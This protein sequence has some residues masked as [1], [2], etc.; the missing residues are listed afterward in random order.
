M[1]GILEISRHKGLLRRELLRRIGYTNGL[2]DI[3]RFARVVEYLYPLIPSSVSRLQSVIVDEERTISGAKY[4]QGVID[5]AGAL[6]LLER[7][8]LTVSLSA[9]G[10]A[11]HALQQPPNTERHWQAFLLYLVVDADGEAT[12]NL[13]D[14]LTSQD[15]PLLE[16]GRLLMDRMIRLMDLKTEWANREVRAGFVKGVVVGEI[17]DARKRLISALD[18][19]KKRLTSSRTLI[20]ERRLSAE[21]RTE[22]FIEHTIVPRRGWLVDLG[23]MLSSGKGFELTPLGRQLVDTFKSTSWY[24]GGIIAMPLSKTVQEVLSVPGEDFEQLLWRAIA[25]A[26]SV[27][28]SVASFS[29]QD[30]LALIKKLYPHLKLPGLNEAEVSALF[31]A[32]SCLEAVDGRVLDRTAF[33]SQ[34][35]A[36]FKAFPNEVFPLRE[37]RGYDGYI[38]LKASPQKE[39]SE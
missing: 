14:L 37:R 7:V 4:A 25:K 15:Y 17:D 6:G 38:S 31:Y 27:L 3:R 21:E 19:S 2:H 1:A 34:L 35:S 39:P 11:L 32:T 29:E 10:Y 18:A 12:L 13:L 36:V 16:A 23:C 22:R 5:V 30:L 28:P 9:R 33:K 26:S 20:E 24:Q 8:G